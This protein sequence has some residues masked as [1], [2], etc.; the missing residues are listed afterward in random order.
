M[1][2]TRDDRDDGDSS[3]LKNALIGRESGIPRQRSHLGDRRRDIPRCS[4]DELCAADGKKDA[5][6]ERVGS[7]DME[8]ISVSLL[9]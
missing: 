9:L 6:D 3:M 8:M 5:F 7:K 2:A 4:F 1:V